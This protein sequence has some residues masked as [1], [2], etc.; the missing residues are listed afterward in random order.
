MNM[1]NLMKGHQEVPV[2]KEQIKEEKT[3]EKE[4]EEEISQEETLHNSQI[5]E[6]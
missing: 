2:E 6:E 3:K 1:L 5:K 4:E